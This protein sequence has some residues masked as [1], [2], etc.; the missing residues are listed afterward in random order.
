MTPDEKLLTEMLLATSKDFLRK[1]FI[2]SEEFDY[3]A[4]ARRIL[5][6]AIMK[7]DIIKKEIDG[8]QLELI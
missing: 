3:L 5:L 7:K 1:G 2:I 8:K 6:A 4:T